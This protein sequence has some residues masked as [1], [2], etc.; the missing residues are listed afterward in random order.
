MLKELLATFSLSAVKAAFTFVS[1]FMAGEYINERRE[2]ERSVYTL[3]LHVAQ[4]I[5]SM[6]DNNLINMQQI[7]LRTNMVCVIAI[8]V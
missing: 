4:G 2:D 8:N 7:C 3:S 6:S 5:I 1:I